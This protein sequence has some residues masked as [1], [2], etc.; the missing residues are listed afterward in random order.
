MQFAARAEPMPI[1]QAVDVLSSRATEPRAASR[2]GGARRVRT[3]SGGA[4]RGLLGRL[5]GTKLACCTNW[6]VKYIAVKRWLESVFS[7]RGV[8]MT[9]R[10]EFRHSVE[11]PGAPKH[12]PDARSARWLA[13]P[14]RTFSAAVVLSCISA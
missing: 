6:R 3:T 10:V 7:P 11:R 5:E 12:E 1:L 14:L 2:H 4:R 9:C 8:V 13:A